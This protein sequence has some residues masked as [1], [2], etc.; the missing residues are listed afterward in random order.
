MNVIENLIINQFGD[1]IL[2]GES[3]KKLV[4]VFPNTFNQGLGHADV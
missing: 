2:R 3:E 1:V 4:F